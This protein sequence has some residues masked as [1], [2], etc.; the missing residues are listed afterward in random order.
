[1][2][3]KTFSI[4]Q[5]LEKGN[6]SLLDSAKESTRLYLEMKDISKVATHRGL[7]IVTIYNHL[8]VT[9][10]LNPYD[11]I[12]SRDFRRVSEILDSGNADRCAEEL[13][14]IFS[15]ESKADY[16]IKRNKSN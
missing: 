10:T 11:Y 14:K 13:N 1:M 12:S 5:Y 6:M 3:S 9:E 16:Y 8:F 2:L 15:V 7:S 4:N